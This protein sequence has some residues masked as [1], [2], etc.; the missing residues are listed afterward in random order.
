VTPEG[1]TLPRV[2]LTPVELSV[3]TGT[4]VPRFE[5]DLDRLL[6]D[7]FGWVGATTVDDVPDAGPSTSRTYIVS[8][9]PVWFQF[10]SS[11]SRPDGG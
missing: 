9:L 8:S 3:A 1:A 6:H 7:A 5:Q 10:E 11:E 2:E 4:L